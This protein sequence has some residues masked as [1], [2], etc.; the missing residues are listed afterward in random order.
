MEL[1]YKVVTDGTDNHLLL[2]NVR[3]SGLTGSKL[4]LLLE[5]AQISVNKNSIYGDTSAIN[6]GGIRLGSPA[7]TSRALKENDFVEI[8]KFLDRGAKIALKIQEKHGKLLKNFVAQL[9]GDEDIKKLKK[10]VEEW[11]SKFPM[12]GIDKEAQD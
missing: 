8:A 2:W 6:P 10:D 7:M 1:G 12:P 3:D 4:E 11:V 9:D 5:K